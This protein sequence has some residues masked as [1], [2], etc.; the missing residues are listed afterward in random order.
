V[1]EPLRM[2]L[3]VACPADHAFATWARRT[4]M[5]WPTGHTVTGEQDLEIVF[6]PRVGGRIYE[7]TPSGREEDWGEV[8]GWDPP[9]RLTYLWHLRA[10]R[11]DATEVEIAFAEQ[12][13]GS[14]RIE[15]E[16]RGWERLG[17]DA[18]AWRDRNG[19]GWARLIPHFKEAAER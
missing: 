17:A 2:S 16:H 19:D 4:S 14:T 6:E 12:S 15:I 9:R 5:W 13:D 10:D 7:R 11:A 8:L 18:Q 3:T 1:N